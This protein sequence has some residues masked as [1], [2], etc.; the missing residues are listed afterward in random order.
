MSGLRLA[1]IVGEGAAPATALSLA[2][3]AA[4]LGRDV[5]ML[6]DGGSVAAL[7][8]P[9]ERLTAALDLGVRIVACQSGLAACNLPAEALPAG[10]ETGGMVGFLAQMADAQLLLA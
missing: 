6:F 7:V 5:A 4:A 9:D 8:A 3:A 2:A 1:I 10:I